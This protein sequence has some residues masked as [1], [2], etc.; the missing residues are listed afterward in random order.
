MTAS[1]SLSVRLF[2]RVALPAAVAL[3]SVAQLAAAQAQPPKSPSLEKH[4]EAA[5]A[6]LTK[7]DTE[8]AKREVRLELQ[9]N[10]L[11]AASHFLLASLLALQGEYDQ[12]IVGFQRTCTLDPANPEALYN[13]GTLLLWKKEALAA[14]KLLEK[15]VTIRPDHVPAYNNLAKAYYLIGLPELAVAS[16]EEALRRDPT[17]VLAL[18]NLAILAEGASLKE[19]AA[20]YRSRLRAARAAG[21]AEKPAA[22][23]VEPI[24]LLP[25]WPLATAS[26][27]APPPAAPVVPALKPPPDPEADTLRQLLRGLPHVTVERAGDRL[28][29]SGWTS[30]PKEKEILGRILAASKNVIDLTT[31]DIADPTRMLEI[32][33]T[34]F[35]VI[36]GDATSVGFNFLQLLQTSLS[37]F[38]SHHDGSGTGLVPPV[39]STGVVPTAAD[40]GPGWATN[41]VTG[42]AREGWLFFAAI[43]YN[44]N[45]ANAAENQVAVLA[46]PHLS[47][48]NGTMATFLAGGD[49]VFQVSGLNSGDIKPYPFGTTLKVTPTLLRT[50]GENGVPR[51]RLSVDA[52]RKSGP[53]TQ[54]GSNN[55]L[56]D[57][58]ETTADAVLDIGQTLILSGLAQREERTS[59]GGVPGLMYIPILKYLFSTKTTTV[60]NTAVLILLTPRDAAYLDKRLQKD[61]AD[62]IELRRAFLQAKHGTPED[63]RRFLERYPDWPVMPPNWLST[64]FFMLKGSEMYRNVSGESLTPDMLNIDVD[65]LGDRPTKKKSS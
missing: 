4:Y 32:D 60:L 40:L 12:A 65:L 54:V 24:T 17:N 21:I 30:G 29:V 14:S 48:L 55:V 31:D 23:A 56:F 19:A 26:V 16:Y 15:A 59:V 46:R 34:I 42:I 9:E 10:P 33:A 8:T 13:L 64:H 62:F 35:L 39:S 36:K 27:S 44:V 57:N 47:A 43:D 18:E 11:H 53:S 45:I 7:G 52:G 49:V 2:R 1:S 22:E 3:L 37:Y 63:M 58:V 50:P 51:V 5:R 61:I 6:A 41:T 28:G 38:S 25:T 20:A